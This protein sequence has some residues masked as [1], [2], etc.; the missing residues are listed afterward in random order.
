MSILIE[1]A[2]GRHD[3]SV[4]ALFNELRIRIHPDFWRRN[5]DTACPVGLRSRPFVAV[6]GEG[7]VVGFASVRT[8]VIQAAREEMR[9]QVLHEFVVAAG[10]LERDVAAALLADLRPLAE[11][12][13]CAGASIEA[14]RLLDQNNFALV[15]HYA[16]MAFDPESEQKKKK[17]R[18]D[19]GVKPLALDRIDSFPGEVLKLNDALKREERIFRRRTPEE[20]DWLF[21]GPAKGF[22]V[23]VNSE[24][25]AYVVLRREKGRADR[26]EL[27]VAD[28]C[29]AM[30]EV[31]R[32][33]FALA[34]IARRE[35]APV[36]LSMMG[37][38][39]TEGFKSAGFVGLRPRWPLYYQ[40][41]DARL[42]TIGN[43][44]LRSEKWSFSAAD[45]E[46]DRW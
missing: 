31:P 3:A 25:G 16:R 26:E 36:Y 19:G 37:R 24:S 21:F 7:N 17:A 32:L 2:S 11:V 29:C 46:V 27:L 45:G 22:E 42:R 38:E 28:A 18:A 14:S 39:W 4:T 20:L 12:T 10:S 30:I 9:A 43:I 41:A 13:L 35:S 15:G 23:Y 44:L 6:D 8:A 40:S 1:P 33:A 34:D 5:Y